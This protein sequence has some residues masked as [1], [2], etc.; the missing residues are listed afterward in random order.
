MWAPWL[1]AT[2]VMMSPGSKR[3]WYTARVATVPLIGRTSAWRHRT[4]LCPRAASEAPA[5]ARDGPVRELVDVREA[6]LQHRLN[7]GPYLGELRVLLEDDLRGGGRGLVDRLADLR[8]DPD[9]DLPDASLELLRDPVSGLV[10]EDVVQ[11]PDVGDGIL[12][13]HGLEAHRAI[14]R[15]EARVPVP[16]ADAP[17]VAV[18]PRQACDG[19]VEDSRVVV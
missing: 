12:P 9:P 16:A 1:R 19:E 11:L 7:L 17:V 14:R 3:A 4:R 6:G 13:R 18:L 10:R 15:D 8:H 5:L 2:D